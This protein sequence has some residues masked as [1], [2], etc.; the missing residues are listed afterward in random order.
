MT[1]TV[2]LCVDGQVVEKNRSSRQF[3]MQVSETGK[4]P[5]GQ[6]IGRLV[7]PSW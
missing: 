4:N 1:P 6:T 5:V 7:S 3:V 2:G